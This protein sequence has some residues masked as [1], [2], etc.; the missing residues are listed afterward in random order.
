MTFRELYLINL[1]WSKDTSLRL[2]FYDGDSID[3]SAHEALKTYGDYYVCGFL[4]DV[5]ELARKRKVLWTG[6]I[7]YE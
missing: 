1:R 4:N 7:R 5:V 2:K 6:G 3:I